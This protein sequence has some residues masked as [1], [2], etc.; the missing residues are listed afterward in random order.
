MDHA[1]LGRIC[2]VFSELFWPF[3]TSICPPLRFW[4][5]R[6]S[7]ALLGYC[8]EFSD[9][10]VETLWKSREPGERGRCFVVQLIHLALRLAWPTNYLSKGRSQ[11]LC[12]FCSFW[13]SEGK[14]SSKNP[15]NSQL[16]TG[17]WGHAGE[18]CSNTLLGPW[19]QWSDLDQGMP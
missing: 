11:A 18:P 17:L 13:H 12:G 10:C 4:R 6:A 7:S 9:R 2:C 8:R 19:F 1:P 3:F 14:R 15:S 5:S 16:G